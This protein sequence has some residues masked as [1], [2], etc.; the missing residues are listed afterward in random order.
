M[1]QVSSIL[2]P[3]AKLTE[4]SRETAGKCAKIFE[5][6]SLHLC[7]G[8]NRMIRIDMQK[9][10]SQLAQPWLSSEMMGQLNVLLQ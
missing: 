2:I 1:T 5:E 7:L 9:A 3:N 4:A 6:L 10:D 8:L